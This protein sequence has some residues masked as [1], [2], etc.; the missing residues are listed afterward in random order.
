MN[1]LNNSCS[2]K[3]AEELD[4]LKKETIKLSNRMREMEFIL[5]EYFIDTKYLDQLHSRKKLA[6]SPIENP[7]SHFD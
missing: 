3:K 6:L 2:S 1:E 4:E 5:S 7:E